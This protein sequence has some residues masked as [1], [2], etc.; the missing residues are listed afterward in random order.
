MNGE[1]YSAKVEKLLF[2]GSIDDPI[3]LRAE[4]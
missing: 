4:K 2:V 1:K 3:T